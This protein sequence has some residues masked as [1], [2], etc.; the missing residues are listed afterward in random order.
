MSCDS[1]RFHRLAAMALV[2]LGVCLLAAGDPTAEDWAARRAWIESLEPQQREQL[3]QRYERF[4]RLPVRRQEDLRSLHA[5]LEQADD[6]DQL[7]EVATRYHQWLATLTAA[8]RATLLSL[9]AEQRVAKIRQIQ[10]KQEEERLRSLLASPLSRE[11]AA[12]IRGW[13]D[14]MLATH[15][16]ELV[17][18]MPEPMRQRFESIDSDPRRRKQV[19]LAAALGAFQAR[20]LQPTSAEMR[21]LLKELSA[22]VREEISRQPAGRQ[23][24][25][26]RRWIA[27][28]AFG[29]VAPQVAAEDLQ[30]F[31]MTLPA[32]E[33]AR[34]ALKPRDQL[35]EELRRL[36]FR[37]KWQEKFDGDRRGWSGP[38]P[39]LRR[40][41]GRT[42]LRPGGL[43]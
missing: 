19:L 43:N 8:E 25:L 41:D 20:P 7:R 42:P 28:A 35:Q 3:R 37:Q 2:L 30:D 6:G 34:L 16:Q 4:Q 24:D 5:A 39:W 21:G 38:P 31:F 12:A 18:G 9:P 29:R 36:Y 40:G 33:Q 27:L 11:D 10:A 23:R 32:E 17:A 22:D 15:E 1:P 13:L 26:L 14:R